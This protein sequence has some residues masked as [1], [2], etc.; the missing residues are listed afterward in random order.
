[1][2]QMNTEHQRTSSF[3]KTIAVL[4]F[5]VKLAVAGA[6][7]GI[8]GI[9]IQLSDSLKQ[10]SRVSNQ[11][12][13]FNVTILGRPDQSTLLRR[14]PEPGGGSLLGSFDFSGVQYEYIGTDDHPL[15]LRMGDD[16]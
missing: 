1:M 9:Q 7:F 14:Q 6:L 4:D 5:L 16:R 15:I 2:S 13:P 8:L 10:L 12:A 3:F 11:D